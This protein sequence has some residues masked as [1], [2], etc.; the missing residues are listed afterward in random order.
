[1]RDKMKCEKCLKKNICAGQAF[2]KYKCSLC[3]KEG[4]HANT[5]VPKVCRICSELNQV[6]ERCGE[7][8]E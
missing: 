2:T 1:M 7:K 8:V 4:L 5:A 6:C 3:K